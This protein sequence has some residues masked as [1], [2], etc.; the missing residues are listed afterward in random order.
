VSIP[1][2][3]L[4]ANRQSRIPLRMLGPDGT[5]LKRRYYSPKSGREIDMEE[6]IHGYELEN[7]RYVVVT[8]EEL[9]RLAPEKSRDIDLRVF[10]PRDS[11]APLFFERAYSLAPARGAIKA[12]RL[13]AEILEK[14]DRAGIATL[15]MRGNEHLVAIL[16]QKGILQAETMHF[17]DEIRTPQEVGL[18]RGNKVPKAAVKQALK[19]IDRRATDRLSLE[20][21]RDEESQRLLQLAEKKYARHKDLV[22][23]AEPESSKAQVIDIIEQLKKSLEQD[24]RRQRKGSPGRVPGARADRSKAELYEQAKALE[25]QGRSSMSRRE[26]IHA[27]DK[28]A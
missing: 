20:E 27:I 2:D 11:I 21:M 18:P 10:V 19:I 3:I 22:V 15:V 7:G 28:A 1:V 12:Y 17:Q 8:D 5:P 9:E 26:L 23:S 13:L 4:P 24:G 14:T 6:L 16:P 25:I